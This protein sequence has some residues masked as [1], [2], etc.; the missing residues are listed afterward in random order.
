MFANMCGYK[1]AVEGG[2]CGVK[3]GSFFSKLP[4][5]GFVGCAIISVALW[6]YVFADVID[7]VWPGFSLF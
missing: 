6:F 3:V 5:I 4:P 7:E 1:A 2:D